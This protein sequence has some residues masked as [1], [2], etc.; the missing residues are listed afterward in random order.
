MKRETIEAA[1]LAVSGAVLMIW[2]IPLIGAALVG[3]H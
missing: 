3:I 1:L 2:G